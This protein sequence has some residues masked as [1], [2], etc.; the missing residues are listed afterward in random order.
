M[1][2]QFRLS[3]EDRTAVRELL[4]GIARQYESLN[5]NTFL[6]RAA[7]IAQQLPVSIREIFYEFKLRE[8]SPVLLITNN[9]VLA[10]DVGPTPT[11]HWRPGEERQ[12]NLPQ[13]MH[14]L[15]ASLLGETFGFET[16]QRGR[17]FNDL[18]TIPGAPDNSSS[19]GGKVGL[20][21][22]DVSP[23]QPFMPDYLGFLCLRNEQC[24]ITTFS[25]LEN[26]NIPDKMLR[27]LF[28]Q[29]FPFKNCTRR[30]VLFGDPQRPYLRYSPVDY[31]QCDSE[32]AAA[33][34]F[35]SDALQRNL[36]NVTL[37]QGDC[38][39][40]DN[41]VAVHGRSPY[42]AEYGANSRWFS[43]LFMLRDLRR[44]RSYTAAPES[45]VMAKE[46]TLNLS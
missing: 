37:S 33:R 16:Q 12:L 45:R 32:M 30:S 43:R 7:L 31:D 35:L 23:T 24:A 10:G 17:I 44:I 36:Q 22:E 28:E 3:N 27:V 8:S 34:Q 38:L 20:H 14:G 42:A 19:G 21:T 1:L 9:P 6:D 11:A 5:E 4:V 26:V 15:Y 29:R 18:I 46:C 41:L 40:L 2:K 39:Y 13:L 25:S